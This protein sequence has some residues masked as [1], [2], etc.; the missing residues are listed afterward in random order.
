MRAFLGA[1]VALGSVTDAPNSVADLVENNRCERGSIDDAPD[2]CVQLVIRDGLVAH[3]LSLSSSRQIV[4][5]LFFGTLF[6]D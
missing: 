3:R 1:A 5:T 6:L 2:G 4:G